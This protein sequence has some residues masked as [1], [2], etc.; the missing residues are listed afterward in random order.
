MESW[1]NCNKEN[2]IISSRVR[3]ARNLKEF[4]FPS[5]LTREEGI[6]AGNKIKEAFGESSSENN[7]YTTYNLWEMSKNTAKSFMEKHLISPNLLKN[8]ESASFIVDNNE[9]ISL[10]I[11]EEDHIRL[12]CIS[13]GYN[14]REAYKKADTI[15]SLLES[16]LDFAF[17]EKLGY[18]TAC[19]T[20]LGTAMR[21]SVMIHLPA[22]TLNNEINKLLKGLSQVGMTLR[23]LYGEGSKGEGNIYQISN[24]VTLGIAEEDILNNLE[25]V[26][27][28]VISQERQL[29]KIYTEQYKYELEDKVFRARALLESARILP[30]NESLSL[31]SNLR[32]GVELGIIG[33]ISI[34][35]INKILIYSQNATLQE[36]LGVSMKE[37]ELNIERAAIIKKILLEP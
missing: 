6:E 18:L 32:L 33:D 13:G 21:A 27:L 36:H 25:A 11:N 29:R 30:L 37:R 14:I 34:K 31:L 3:L 9:T 23:G 5:R 10:M 17:N 8:N 28:Q 19:P 35:K 7:K 4:Q 20:N 12:Q 26:T 24:Q 15:D 16:K 22:L 1:V 2:I